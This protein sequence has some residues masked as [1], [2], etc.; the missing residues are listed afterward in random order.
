[1]QKKKKDPKRRSYAAMLH[2]QLLRWKKSHLLCC[3]GLQ[4]E[5][6][7]GSDGKGAEAHADGVGSTRL[8]RAVG[9]AGSWLRRAG[10]RVGA[11]AASRRGTT[12]G[13]GDGSGSGDDREG[14]GLSG[15]D[16]PRADTENGAF[17]DRV[18]GDSSLVV[19][20]EDC[21]TLL[22]AFGILV[23]LAFDRL[24]ID[25]VGRNDLEATD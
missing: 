6:G 24:D 25:T 2:D 7:E 1:M 18:G 3:P 14:S 13:G 22:L 4:E 11:V 12:G 16:F 20:G 19:D 23:S 21:G 8:V 10:G 9:G 15:G 17:L 5:H